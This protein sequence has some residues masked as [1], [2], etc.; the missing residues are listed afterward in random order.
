[1]LNITDPVLADVEL[2][3]PVTVKVVAPAN[4]NVGLESEGLLCKTTLPVP[5][6]VVLPVPPLAIGKAV[7]DKVI[8]RVPLLVIGEPLILKNVGTDAATEVTV[9]EP[10]G[11]VH[12]I[13]LLTPP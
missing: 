6:E 4:P 12:V 7:P 1:L 2:I 8:A 3:D 9:P 5:V 10:G 11:V 13:A